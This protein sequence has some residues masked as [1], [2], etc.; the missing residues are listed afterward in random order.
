MRGS[1]RT[2]SMQLGW[3]AEGDL[4]GALLRVGPQADP[5]AQS[6]ARLSARALSLAER[7]LQGFAVTVPRSKASSALESL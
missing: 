1:G 3:F 2:C 5:G 4:Q 6:L 7:V